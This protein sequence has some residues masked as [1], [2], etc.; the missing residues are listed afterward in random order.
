[1]E[2]SRSELN[3]PDNKITFLS[4]LILFYQD[5]VDALMD[6]NLPIRALEVADS[7][8]AHMLAEG[9]PRKGKLEAGARGA[10]ELKA[11]ARRSGSTWLS[12]W[13]APRRSFLWVVTPEEIRTFVLPP[14]SEIAGA[15]ERYRGFI[16]GSMRDPMQTESDAGRWLVR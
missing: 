15:V 7:S 6:R 16:E 9:L 14:E 11:L 12:Y 2:Q 13:V 5:Y 3:G 1:M 8:R 10:E 4:R